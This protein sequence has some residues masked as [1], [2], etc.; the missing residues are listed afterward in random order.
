MY[1]V[2]AFL[3]EFNFLTKH[4]NNCLVFLYEFVQDL[5]GNFFNLIVVELLYQPV[6]D[7]PLYP[8]VSLVDVW[9]VV[10]VVH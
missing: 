3:K 5:I 8:E 6:E 1:T 7:V 2:S 4:G 10:L 9:D